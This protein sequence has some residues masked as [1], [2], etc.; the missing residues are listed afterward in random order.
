MKHLLAVLSISLVASSCQ[1]ARTGVSNPIAPSMEPPPPNAPFYPPGSWTLNASVASV[2]P[3][4]CFG[5]LTG[6]TSEYK[7]VVRRA[8]ELRLSVFWD[9]TDGIEYV[10][11]LSGHDFS[12]AGR[13]NNGNPFT[14]GCSSRGQV[15]VVLTGHVSGRFSDDGRSLSAEEVASYLFVA[16][17]E[18]VDVRSL[19]IA[20]APAE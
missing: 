5:E 7:L 12:V 2:T 1:E 16:T 10:G 6:L 13:F 15:A 8:E 14:V 3:H 20:T 11:S 9:P 4:R 17:G 19:W 18:Q